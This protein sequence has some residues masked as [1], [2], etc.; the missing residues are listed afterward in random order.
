MTSIFKL[1]K[2]HL[3]LIVIFVLLASSLGFSAFE[4]FQ[5]EMQPENEALEKGDK[6]DPFGNSDNNGYYD[7]I[8]G[9]LEDVIIPERRKRKHHH[10]SKGDHSKTCK[11]KHCKKNNNNDNYFN[12]DSN[13]YILK[14]EIVPPVCPKC[15]DSRMCPKQKSSSEETDSTGGR[16]TGGGTTGGGTS[17]GGTTG[18][19]TWGG[20]MNNNANGQKSCPACPACA[21]CPEPSFTCKKVPNY[22]VST[23]GTNNILP[24][25]QLNSF[26]AFN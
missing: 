7:S 17:G 18:G 25:P 12:P 4:Y 10:N 21:R 9:D 24:I 1:N 14:S 8:V 20:N 15:P 19:N 5:S 2:L 13:K 6:Y 26:A 11:C 23:V 22:A 16:S 3:F